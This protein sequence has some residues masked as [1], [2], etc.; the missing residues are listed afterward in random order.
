MESLTSL[1]INTWRK[2]GLWSPGKGWR[3]TSRGLINHLG[4]DGVTLIKPR[5][6]YGAT[7]VPSGAIIWRC[8]GRVN[9]NWLYLKQLLTN[10][11]HF[12]PPGMSFWPIIPVNDCLLDPEFNLGDEAAKSDTSADGV[13]LG[14]TVGTERC[15][16]GKRRLEWFR[17]FL[18]DKY[19]FLGNSTFQE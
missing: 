10:L 16:G 2:W 18:M 11:C 5:S 6:H 1:A 8:T 3:P 7:I 9:L 14:I 17:L 4:L 19:L 13:A 12:H 15:W